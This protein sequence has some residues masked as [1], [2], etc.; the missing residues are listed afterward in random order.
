VSLGHC[1][2]TLN[3]KFFFKVYEINAL[4]IEVFDFFKE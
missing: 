4:E 3:S 2:V 1:L